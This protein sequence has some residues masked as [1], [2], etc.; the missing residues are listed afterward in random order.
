MS[1]TQRKSMEMV[2]SVYD[3]G[4]ATING[5]DYYFTKC[6]HTERKKVFAF[7]TEVQAEVASGSFAFMGRSDFEAIERI[8]CSRVTYQGMQLTKIPNHWDDD[9]HADDYL[10]FVTTAMAVI[11]Y[12]FMKGA[13]GA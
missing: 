11:S 8:I 3:D 10:Q 9:E 1:D 7:F 5:S 12:P 13:L 4:V 6:T 2:K